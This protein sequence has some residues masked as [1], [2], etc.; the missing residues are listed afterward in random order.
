MKKEMERRKQNF[1]MTRI[2]KEKQ[3]IITGQIKDIVETEFLDTMLKNKKV[4]CHFY[5][6]DFE[7]CKI[8]EKHL[9]IIALTH[10]ET[11]FVRIDAEKT[12]F[13]T[14]KLN[15]KVLPTVVLFNDGKA[16]DRIIGFDELGLKDDFPTINLTRRL[17]KAKIIN[18]KNKS[19]SGEVSITKRYGKNMNDDDD[20]DY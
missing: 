4:I 6:K 5:H 2:E 1:E 10:G 18:A 9:E 16:Y 13:F 8:M 14:T 19:E 15:I 7:R 11:V 3:K 12:P 17:V 20:L